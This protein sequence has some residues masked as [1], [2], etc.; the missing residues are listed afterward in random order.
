LRE[1]GGW[2]VRRR[3]ERGEHNECGKR[4]AARQHVQH[5]K[6]DYEK[7]KVNEEEVQDIGEKSEVDIRE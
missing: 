7:K 3:A 4:S 6:G 2:Y 1:Q 5:L